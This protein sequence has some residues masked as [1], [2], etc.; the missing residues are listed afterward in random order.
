M[1]K[2]VLSIEYRSTL[3]LLNNSYSRNSYHQLLAAVGTIIVDTYLS[4]ILQ[5]NKHLNVMYLMKRIQVIY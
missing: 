2:S 1:I 4:H 5:K 3:L